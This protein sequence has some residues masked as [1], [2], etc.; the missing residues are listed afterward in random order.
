M[1]SLDNFPTQHLVFSQ[2]PDKRLI[3]DFAIVPLISLLSPL[4]TFIGTPLIVKINMS[5]EAD[6]AVLIIIDLSLFSV[7]FNI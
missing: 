3:T 1:L 7:S 4:Y 6:C 5:A 2:I